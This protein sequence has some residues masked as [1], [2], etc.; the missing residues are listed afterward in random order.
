MELD[1]LFILEL[2]LSKLSLGRLDI[3]AWYREEIMVLRTGRMYIKIE[4]MKEPGLVAMPVT[5]AL[6]GQENQFKAN[7]G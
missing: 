3:K 2:A 4:R 6:G 5:P 7:L 1:W